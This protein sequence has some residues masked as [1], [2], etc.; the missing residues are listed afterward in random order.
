MS[1]TVGPTSVRV[2]IDASSFTFSGDANGGV[3]P[4]SVQRY[5]EIQQVSGNHTVVDIENGDSIKIHDIDVTFT[6]EGG[7]DTA[8][9]VATIN[10]LTFKHHV[11]AVDGEGILILK[12]QPQYEILPV[13][14]TG[15]LVILEK[16]GF[17]TPVVE[18]PYPQV[19]S[20][21]L[22][23]AKTRGN[24]RWNLVVANLSVENTPLSVKDVTLV[25]QNINARPS[26]IAFTV[27]YPDFAEI[28]TFDETNNNQVIKGTAAIKRMVA[29]AFT[30][31][32][33][34]V[35]VITDPSPVAT[36]GTNTF[37]RGDRAEHI[38][39]AQLFDNIVD[40]EAVVSV[41]VL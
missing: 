23:Q 24:V 39:T 26:S 32:V 7:L 28:Y 29:R 2:V 31:T 4:I 33:T 38:T 12:Q 17:V 25:G 6:T 34:N 14:V 35:Q 19:S 16:L 20:F 41:S 40:A 21:A 10:A 8:G 11:V 30:T 5:R 18:Y 36:I 27:T 15:D 9:I 37:Q 13:S 1:E 3:D 22:S